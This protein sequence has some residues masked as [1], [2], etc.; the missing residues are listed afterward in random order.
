[1][2]R[3]TGRN[4]ARFPHN[5]NRKIGTAMAESFCTHCKPMAQDLDSTTTKSS[6]F[7]SFFAIQNP[8]SSLALDVVRTIVHWVNRHWENICRVLFFG[9]RK[10]TI[11]LGTDG[12]LIAAKG[13]YAILKLSDS[14]QHQNH[15]AFR[16]KRAMNIY[17]LSKSCRMNDEVGV[18]HPNHK[19]RKRR[20]E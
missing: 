20:S 6:D 4:R 15:Q 7:R 12:M 11:L 3:C 1:M 14:P 2:R 13:R 10:S 9:E 19:G 17:F 8:F 18:F 16:Y 5:G